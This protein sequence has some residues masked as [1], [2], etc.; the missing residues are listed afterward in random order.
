MIGPLRAQRHPL[1]L[2]VSMPGQLGATHWL[3]RAEEAR[4][5]AERLGDETARRQMLQIA[6]SYEKLAAQAIKR[7][8]GEAMPPPR[9]LVNTQPA[10]LPLRSGDRP[11]G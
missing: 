2:G 10:L 7:A 11:A 1:F 6:A 3:A 8:A 9:L 4:M 5:F